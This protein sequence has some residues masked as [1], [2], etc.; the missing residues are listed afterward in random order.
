MTIATPVSVGSA[1]AAPPDEPGTQNS[2]ASIASNSATFQV[3]D[4]ALLGVIDRGGAVSPTTVTGTGVLGG[5]WTLIST[6][7][8]PSNTIRTRVFQQR[9][10]TAGAGTATASWASA[11]TNPRVALVP[12]RGDLQVSASAP[13]AA[14]VNGSGGNLIGGTQTIPAGGML[15]A[16]IATRKIAFLPTQAASGNT[17]TNNTDQDILKVRFSATAGSTNTTF[18]D[19]GSNTER[20]MVGVLLTESAGVAA[21]VVSNTSSTPSGSSVTLSG[22]AT[23]L[24]AVTSASATVPALGT[25]PLTVNG[26][27][28]TFSE[29]SWNSRRAGVAWA[30]AGGDAAG[31]A[32]TFF[33]GAALGELQE[34]SVTALTQAIAAGSKQFLLTNAAE[35]VVNFALPARLTVNY[36]NS[37]QQVITGTY[38]S[39]SSASPTATAGTDTYLQNASIRGILDFASLSVPQGATITSAL[40]RLSIAWDE[41]S[42]GGVVDVRA[43]TTDRYSLST[44]VTGVPPATYAAGTMTATNSGGTSS[45]AVLPGFAIAGGIPAAPT[46]AAV[47]QITHNS[48]RANWAD[49]SND[50]TGFQVQAVEHPSNT[51]LVTL[52][53]PTNATSI[54]FNAG[55]SSAVSAAAYKTRVRATGSGGPSDW[56]AYSTV[57]WTDNPV[58][59]TPSALPVAGTQ[60]PAPTPTSADQITHNSARAQWV[61]N[62]NNETG[63]TAQFV[64][65]PAEVVLGTFNAAANTLSV[66]ATGLLPAAAI[67]YRV[68]ALGSPDSDYS[69]YS[70]VFTTDNPVTGTPTVVPVGGG[71][72]APQ[73][74]TDGPIRFSAGVAASVQ[75]VATGQAPITW[76][77]VAGLLPAGV[78]LSQNGTLAKTASATVGSATVT[79]RASNASGNEEKPFIIGSDYPDAFLSAAAANLKWRTRFYAWA[80]KDRSEELL[81]V[82]D[83]RR[84]LVDNEE[85]VG[86]PSVTSSLLSGVATPALAVSTPYVQGQYIVMKISAGEYSGRYDLRVQY[87]TSLGQVVVDRIEVL[88][89]LASP[90]A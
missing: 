72:Q 46:I 53:A 57:F 20:S 85:I 5:T 88:I 29:I 2:A 70:P 27:P 86:N 3:G 35:I 55:N 21:P 76:A 77:V 36:S 22:T 51:E 4:L 8:N 60:P 58:T 65:H 49:N 1:T 48:F 44:T 37:T 23:S 19:G 52:N 78:T 10:T 30:A 6:G 83:T 40:L 41:S 14:G 9:V 69:A 73:I 79:I 16:F 42:S 59:G 71:G 31:T 75:L 63:F 90:V 33:T 54:T 38:K 25:Y 28:N 7:T 74:A 87:N 13:F 18:E 56:S 50:E 47:D 26:L 68:K 17:L 84:R 11:V 66:I 61:D 89:V 32:V 80:E 39:V 82:L 67:K 34:I 15:M 12:I 43:L 81:L 64:T 62:S 24:A 45:P